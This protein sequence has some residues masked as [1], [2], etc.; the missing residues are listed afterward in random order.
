M[1][2]ESKRFYDASKQPCWAT[3]I[4]QTNSFG[5]YRAIWYK[6]GFPSLPLHRT[7]KLYQDP[8]KPCLDDVHQEYSIQLIFS[9]SFILTYHLWK[10]K[11]LSDLFFW[12]P[13][14]ARVVEEPVVLPARPGSIPVW[15]DFRVSHQLHCFRSTV[16]TLFTEQ[17]KFA[18]ASQSL[19][20]IGE[21]NVPVVPGALV[22]I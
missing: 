15:D 17:C 22:W 19:R 13:R 21:N 7:P 5:A 8:S 6:S 18:D 20:A 3:T 16:T 9:D 1:I 4:L 2:T 11:V 10:C 14:V 12:G